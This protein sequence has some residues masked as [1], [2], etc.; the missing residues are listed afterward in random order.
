MKE[1]IALASWNI[2]KEGFEDLS[3]SVVEAKENIQS[4]MVK[5]SKL[6]CAG[7]NLP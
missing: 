6:N 2:R 4:P 3:I 1:T 5:Y 7:S